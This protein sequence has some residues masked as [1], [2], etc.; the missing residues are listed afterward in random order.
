MSEV[1]AAYTG[2][3]RFKYVKYDD[4]SVTKQENLKRFF[5]Q[6]EQLAQDSLP[7]GRAKSLVMTH[8]EIAYMW[9]GKAIRDEQIGRGLQVEHVPERSNA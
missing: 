3:G 7:E 4:I 1:K 6:L 5:E 8:L 9:T 2:S